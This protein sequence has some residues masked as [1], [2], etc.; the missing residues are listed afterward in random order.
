MSL[1]KDDIMNA[2]AEMSVMD[3][4]E[5]ITMM[6]KKFGVTAA[7]AAAPTSTSEAEI[8]EE[9]TE[10]NVV[11]ISAGDKKVSAIKAVRSATGLGLKE[12]KNLVESAPVNV[13]ESISKEEA[14][15]LKKKLEE[16]GVTIEIK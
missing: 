13:K 10:F 4:V 2:V 5:L 9:Q 12:A 11:L 8:V 1:S 15:E 14:E 7:I 6:E 3:I 16:S